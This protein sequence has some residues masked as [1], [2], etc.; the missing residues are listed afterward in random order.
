MTLTSTISAI[1]YGY[2]FGRQYQPGS[3]Q[4]ILARLAQGDRIKARYPVK[5]IKDAVAAAMK[6]RKIQ[7]AARDS[8][9]GSNAAQ[10]RARED[11]QK[12]SALGLLHGVARILDTDDAFRERLT[13]F[14][15]D[16]FTAVGKTPAARAAAPAY[17]DEAIRPHIAG[18]FADML[19]AV[20]THPFMLAYL[21]Q[22]SSVGPASLVGKRRGRGLNE[23]L[24]REVLELHTL[25]VG[26]AY[27]QAD[28]RQ[29][30]ELMTGL[31]FTPRKGFAFEAG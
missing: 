27:G 26:G 16:H 1:R 25:G 6:F 30:A 4:D 12:V 24:A 29:L 11:L 7:K 14:W 10:K 18:R 5:S 2:G 8:K 23:N 20:V 3:G 9:P 13:W 21:D 17:I 15:A 19:K 31:T 22:I 28:V